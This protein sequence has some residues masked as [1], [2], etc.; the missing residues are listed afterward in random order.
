MAIPISIFDHCITRVSYSI[1]LLLCCLGG[2]R[3]RRDATTPSWAAGGG[4]PP[5]PKFKSNARKFRTYQ[6]KW[7]EL[8][9]HSAIFYH[10]RLLSY[11]VVFEQ[12]QQTEATIHHSRRYDVRK[13]KQHRWCLFF[14]FTA[15]QFFPVFFNYGSL[16]LMSASH[17]ILLI[18][19]L[20]NNSWLA[21]CNN[22]TV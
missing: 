19:V 14:E 11:K 15:P 17:F 16:S 21:S 12:R 2:E 8:F 1:E 10:V 18:V 13:Q 6:R 20:S 9:H 4:W 5:I 7:S 3:R 22:T